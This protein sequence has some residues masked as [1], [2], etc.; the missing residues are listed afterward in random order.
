MSDAEL[1]NRWLR[2]VQTAPADF[3]RVKFAYQAAM[4]DSKP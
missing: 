3:L 1:R 4:Q 2:R